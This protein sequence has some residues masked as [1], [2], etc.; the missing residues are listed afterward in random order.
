MSTPRS[1]AR[2]ADARASLVLVGPVG[3]GDAA[4][5][6]PALAALLARPNV[7][8]ARRAAARSA[9]RA[10]SRH[11][12]VGADAVPRQRPHARE[13]PA[14][15]LGVPRGGP[16]GGRD[17][18]PEPRASSARAGL[19]RLAAG[20]GPSRP[21]CARRRRSRRCAASRAP[22]RARVAHDWP[23]RIEEL[24]ARRR[25]R[26]CA[27]AVSPQLASRAGPYPRAVRHGRPR[28][29]VERSL[30][31]H[32]STPAPSPPARRPPEQV[33]G[34]P[35]LEPAVHPPPGDR[36][37]P[38]R[39]QHHRVQPH[40]EPRPLP[41]EGG[42]PLPGP[43]PL[44][45]AP[46]GARRRAH[47]EALPPGRDPRPL[48]LVRAAHAAPEAVPAHPDASSR[49]AA[50]TSARRCGSRTSTG[51]T[52]CCSS[53]IEQIV[54]VSN[55]LR[56]EARRHRRSVRT[57]SQVIYRGTNVEQFGWVDRSE[58]DPARPLRILMVGRLVEK[59]G[60]RYAFEAARR[61]APAR[62]PG[63]AHRGG[64]GR[65]L[66]EDPR[67]RRRLGLRARSSSRARRNH[68][69]VRA[70]WPTPTCCCTAR[71]RRRAATSRASRTSSS[72]RRPWACRWSARATAASSRRARRARPA[73]SST[74]ATCP[75]WSRRSR[76]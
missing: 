48:R 24:C 65:G 64:R 42:D 30:W 45:A 72:R 57:A 1:S 40:R 9:A 49:S 20:P 71:S 5:A 67:L 17:A 55:D 6:P 61:A 10:D 44:R 14:Q 56:S 18:A 70:T 47:A 29:A 7:A 76:R 53:A 3:L 23:A 21:P 13:P 4:G 74:S 54:C 68:A 26:A 37:R 75:R 51:S 25:R 52:G 28:R 46:R 35:L 50:A 19:A 63:G 27:R 66:P 62:R 34:V 60:H 8:R 15:A 39:P 2:S 12:D 36:A 16:A 32:P 43:L 11:C 22:R 41:G 33:R 73:T 31:P 58:S 69:G 59:K 38:A